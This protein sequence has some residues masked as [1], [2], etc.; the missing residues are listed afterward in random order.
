MKPAARTTAIV[1]PTARDIARMIEAMIPEIAA[2]KTTCRTTSNRVAPIA[3]APS[4]RP[5][6]TARIASSEIEAMS[7]VMRR[8]TTIPAESG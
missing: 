3:K 6:G 2:G 5:R 1:S 8:P 4:R 7:G